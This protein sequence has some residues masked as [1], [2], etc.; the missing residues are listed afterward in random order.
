[1]IPRILHFVWI[2]DAPMPEWAERNLDAF[3]R[4]NPDYE[5]MIHGEEVLLDRYR[6]IYDRITDLCSRADLLRYSA[7]QRY[8][9]F[10]FDIDFWPLRPL[11]DLVR[12]WSLNGDTMFLTEQ[13]GHLNPALPI[14]NGV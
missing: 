13:N 8:G 11:D 12:A 7:L 3:G 14:A 2:G 1:M 5:V 9:G 4:L 6:P 10:Y